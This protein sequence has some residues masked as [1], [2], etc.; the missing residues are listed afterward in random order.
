MLAWGQIEELANAGIEVGAHTHSHPQLD[1][2]RKNQLKEELKS[3]K[4]IL[5][6]HLGIPIRG[7]AYPFG[8]SSRNVRH[9]A[10]ET[11]YNYACIVGNQLL[12]GVSDSFSLPRLTVKR[13]THLSTFEELVSRNNVSHIFW[14]E[15]LLTKGWAIARRTRGA[16]G[17]IPW[18][19]GIHRAHIKEPSVLPDYSYTAIQ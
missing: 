6:D 5:E 4:A 3:S 19:L 8:Y 14:R 15:H 16:L 2:I 17:Y 1:Q 11:G 10:Q 13:S 12:E 9:M 18:A 7:M